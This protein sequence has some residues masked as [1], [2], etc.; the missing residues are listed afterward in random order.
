MKTNCTNLVDLIL[1]LRSGI[2][3]QDLVNQETL[4]EFKN[5]LKCNLR[6]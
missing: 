2:T 3:C 4:F 6:V 1:R 5:G